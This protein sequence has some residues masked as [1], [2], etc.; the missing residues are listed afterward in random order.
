M[1][2]LRPILPGTSSF[3]AGLATVE[4]WTSGHPAFRADFPGRMFI[5]GD[6]GNNT[7]EVLEFFEI[8]DVIEDDLDLKGKYTAEPTEE[9]ASIYDSSSES[10]LETM[11][12]LRG[13]YVKRINSRL[14]R[15]GK[16]T[17][18]LPY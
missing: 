10:S 18:R 15:V 13:E 1:C 4:V 7:R 12:E 5:Q 11:Q 2:Y 3:V 17:R 9:N 8:D 6:R 14:P 16:R